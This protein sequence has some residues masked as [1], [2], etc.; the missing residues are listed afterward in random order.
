M[1]SHTSIPDPNAG[2]GGGGGITYPQDGAKVGMSGPTV[3]V[4][5]GA[6]VTSSSIFTT[7]IYQNTTDGLTVAVG[8]DTPFTIGIAGV[9]MM[10]FTIVLD[11]NGVGG[12]IEVIANLFNQ[13][14]RGSYEV[15]TIASGTRFVW[16]GV[17][18][19]NLAV[20][21]TCGFSITNTSGTAIDVFRITS[22]P[23]LWIQRVS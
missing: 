9:Y 11:G 6:T 10:G 2:G 14:L 7:S 5:A 17:T 15:P 20:G 18:T 4:G 16:S 13:G 21:N 22:L 3:T 23:S 1:P 8:T 19:G 12:H